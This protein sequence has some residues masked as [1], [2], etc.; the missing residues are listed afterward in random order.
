MHGIPADTRGGMEGVA[1][2]SRKGL[3]KAG[4]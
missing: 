3:Y 1:I 2:D 4:Y